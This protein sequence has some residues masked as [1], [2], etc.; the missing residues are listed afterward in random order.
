HALRFLIDDNRQ[1]LSR[2]HRVNDKLRGIFVPENNIDTL[3]GKFVGHGLHTRTA[4]TDAGAYRIKPWIV[5]FDGDLRTHTGVARCAANVD[6]AL[7]DFRH[8]NLEKLDQK[9]GAGAADK[10]LWAANFGTHFA[11]KTAQT[12]ARPYGF[13]GNH[14]FLADISLG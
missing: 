12:V 11:Q 8:F 3:A 5:G 14:V 10:Q 6:Q 7:P 2:R 13:T 9:L 4:H 1:H